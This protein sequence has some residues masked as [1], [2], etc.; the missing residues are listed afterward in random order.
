MECI[1]KIKVD[2]TKNLRFYGVYFYLTDAEG[3][4]PSPLFFIWDTIVICKV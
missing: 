2:T 4:G 1:C 3:E